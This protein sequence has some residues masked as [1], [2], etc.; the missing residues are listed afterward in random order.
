MRKAQRLMQ[1]IMTI[2][3]RR[4]F[5]VKELADEFG[6][7]SRTIARD[8]R[9]LEELGMPIYAVQGRGG[10]HRLLRERLLPPIS[11]AE[12]E[13]VALYFAAQSMLHLSALPFGEGAE[14]ALR[15]FYHY[16]PADAR[17][18]IDRLQDR[19]MFWSPSRPMSPDTLRVLLEAIMARKV[20]TI[21]YRSEGGCEER[22]IQPIG[23]YAASG[24]WY[25]PAYCFRREA[26][27]QFRAD[28]IESAVINDAMPGREDIARLSLRDKPATPGEGGAG[29]MRLE[30]KLTGKGVWQLA[31]DGRFAPYIQH[32]AGG[33]GTAAIPIAEADLP[34]Y[35]DRILALGPEAV[36]TG[37]GEAI[38]RLREKV[39]ALNGLYGPLA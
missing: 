36:V 23:L 29:A 39:Q 20:V 21:G 1:L 12:S 10:G 19:V 31:S 37:P 27:R 22:D 13:A 5:T 26:L 16:L 17:E 38:A 2:N 6:L 14:A 8:L 33:G 25:C 4:S 18:R 15:K 35:L 30:L 9:E 34:F 28:R 3:A 32:S 11:F 7:S 24:Y